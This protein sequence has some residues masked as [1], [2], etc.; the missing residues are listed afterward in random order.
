MQIFPIQN[1]LMRTFKVTHLC[2][3]VCVEYPTIYQHRGH[4]THSNCHTYICIFEKNTHSYAQGIAS[5]FTPNHILN[6][7]YHKLPTHTQN[8][9]TI[10]TFIVSLTL[11]HIG[12]IFNIMHILA[13]KRE[14]RAIIHSFRKTIIHTLLGISCPLY[15]HIYLHTIEKHFPRYLGAKYQSWGSPNSYKQVPIF[16]LF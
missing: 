6:I 10:Q 16:M 4:P 12:K 13:F 9:Y 15:L 14:S 8:I 2:T 3:C 11:M 5:K 7:C 1:E